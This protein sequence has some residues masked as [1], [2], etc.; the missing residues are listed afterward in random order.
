MSTHPRVI[1]AI[2]DLLAPLLGTLDR[3]EWV[4]RHL[5]QPEAARLAERLAPGADAIMPPLRALE[6]CACPDELDF[7]RER[8]LAVGRQTLDLVAAF[9]EAAG[10]RADPIDL[11]RALRRLARIQEAFYPLAPALELVSC[12]FLE[13]ARR[14]DAELVA[15]LRDGALR[16][17]GPRVG[18]LH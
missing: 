18:V 5:Y 11:Y 16:E 6:E 17:D 9:V 2:G 12:W 4:K 7:V 8:L 1:D 3:V 14:G 10:A 15:R 13:P